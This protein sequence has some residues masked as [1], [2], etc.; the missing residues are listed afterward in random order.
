MCDTSRTRSDCEQSAGCICHLAC[1]CQTLIDTVFLCIRLVN[2]LQKLIYRSGISQCI[3]KI[4]IHHQ[5]RQLAEYIQMHIV[6]RIWCRDQKDQC[7][8]LIIQCLKIHT[9][10]YDHCCESR[11][12]DGVT[13]AVRN[14]NSLSDSGRALFLSR[15][16][17]FAV[18]LNI[19]D[20]SA[21]RHQLYH[22]IQR[23]IF[24][25]GRSIQ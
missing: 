6:L 18:A 23:V 5:H 17:L 19:I 11:L 9:I 3:G 8:R 10:F 16:D 15:I 7:N 22:L 1:I 2:D 20:F 14:R 4:L 13:F 21:A 25:C 12:S 24:S